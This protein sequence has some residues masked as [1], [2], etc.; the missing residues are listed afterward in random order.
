MTRPGRGT[1]ARSTGAAQGNVHTSSARCHRA[2]MGDFGAARAGRWRTG[3]EAWS[4]RR[5][6]MVTCS[7]GE[8]LGQIRLRA[9]C[10]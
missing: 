2:V 5:I 6:S 3:R 1:T 7:A 9:A 8:Y 10:R 4:S